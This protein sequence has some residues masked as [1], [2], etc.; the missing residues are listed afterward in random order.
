MN[1]EKVIVK[2]SKCKESFDS[3]CKYRLYHDGVIRC[4]LCKKEVK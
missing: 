4:F 2:K 1:K 3:K